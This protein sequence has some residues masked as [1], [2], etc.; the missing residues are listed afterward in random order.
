MFKGRDQGSGIGG[1]IKYDD[2]LGMKY[3]DFCSGPDKDDGCY[4]LGI[5]INRRFGK[6]LPDYRLLSLGMANQEKIGQFRTGFVKIRG[7]RPEAG[8]LVLIQKMDMDGFHIG[9]IIESGYFMEATKEAG[10]R[11]VRMN[12]VLVKDRIEGVYRYNCE[13]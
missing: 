10:V 5:E 13:L 12:N 9:V 4:G 11:K 2:L 6:P 8:D 7:Q 1:Q 3:E